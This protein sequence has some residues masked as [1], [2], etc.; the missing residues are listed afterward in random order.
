MNC[1]HQ[2]RLFVLGGKNIFDAGLSGL[3]LIESD[4]FCAKLEIKAFLM[5]R[6]YRGNGISAMDDLVLVWAP[7]HL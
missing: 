2:Q 7:A 4:H 3:N 6:I 5:K 1:T